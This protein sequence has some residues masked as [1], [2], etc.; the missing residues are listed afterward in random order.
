MS[1][2][3]PLN[4]STHIHFVGVSPPVRKSSGR[5][6][7][8]GPDSAAP[9]PVRRE[10][11]RPPN[12][13]VD[14]FALWLLEAAGLNPHAY[15]AAAV[16]RR[17]PACLRQLQVTSGEAARELV[18]QKP[19]VLPK[20]LNTLLIGVTEF[21]RD[22]FVFDFLRKSALPELLRNRPGLR[23]CSAGVSE[24]HELYSI[25][26]LLAE[27]GRLKDCFLMGVDC[28][29]EAIARARAG[30]FDGKEVAGLDS[31][32]LNLFFQPAGQ[33]F[34]ICDE[35]RRHTHWRLDN[36]FSFRETHPWDV[37]LFRNVAIYVNQE[38]AASIWTK[39]CAELSPGGLL[40]TGKAEKPLA[41]LPLQRIAPCVFRKEDS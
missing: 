28:R 22:P 10:P 4:D 24:G 21:F 41:S 25:A 30:R 14:P 9:Q 19:E 38:H 13:P 16:Q 39:L 34:F 3:K 32:L 7:I 12:V 17:V 11:F 27:A 31:R 2:G 29:P 26:M 18:R 5:A 33:G 40:V 1:L 36:L 35:I 37:I 6:L 23:I 8:A 15:R 20:A